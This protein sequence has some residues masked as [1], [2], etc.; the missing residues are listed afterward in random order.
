MKSNI[1]YI[2]R[3]KS[4]EKD[5]YKIGITNDLSKRLRSIQTGNSE[6]VFLEHHEEIPEYIKITEMENWLHSV[7]GN[8]RKTGEWFENISVNEIRKQIFRFL[9]K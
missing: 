9:I 1:L 2:L 3:S 6:K 7:F 4:G 8:N 5:I